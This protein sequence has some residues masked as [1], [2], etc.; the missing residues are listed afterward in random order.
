MGCDIHMVL[1]VQGRRYESDEEGLTAE[2][3]AAAR[4][5]AAP[6]RVGIGHELLPTSRDYELFHA[7]AGVRSPPKPEWEPIA[8]C[9]GLPEDACAATRAFLPEGGSDLHSHSWLSLDEALEG[10]RERLPDHRL[11]RLLGI[12]KDSTHYKLDGLRLVFAFDN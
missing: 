10:L 7:L 11:T 6:W 9:R 3:D 4:L 5:G 1:E 8:D 12:L 2:E